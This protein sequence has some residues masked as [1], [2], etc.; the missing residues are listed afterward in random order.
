[1]QTVDNNIVSRW[2]VAVPPYTQINVAVTHEVYLSCVKDAWQYL[3]KN[4]KDHAVDAGI[5]PEEL[6]LRE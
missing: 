1:V 4:G 2:P 3:L 5:R 6:I